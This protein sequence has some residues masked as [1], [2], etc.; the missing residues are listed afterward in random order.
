MTLL[1]WVV[2][3]SLLS[4]ACYAA[5][6][7]VQEQL[8]TA[9]HRNL[10]RWIGALLLTGAGVGLHVIALRLGTVGVVQALGTLT[11]LLALPIA[12]W[13]SRTPITAVA[14]RDAALTVG[15]LA[16]IM[17][18]TADPAGAA[19][20][21]RDA[22]RYVALTALAVVAVLARL[23]R[24]TRTPVARSLAYATAS[25]V[26]FAVAS[27]FTKAVLISFSV[28]GAVCV[29][30]FASGGYLLGQLSYRE[31]GLAAPLAAVSVS[32]PVVAAVVGVVVFG[33]GFRFGASGLTLAVVAG[34]VAGIGVVG[35]SRRTAPDQQPAGDLVSDRSLALQQPRKR[36]SDAWSSVRDIVC[37]ILV[38]AGYQARPVAS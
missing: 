27:V 19:T 32:N 35:L 23:A 17:A 26:A 6:A 14:W 13:R 30:V 31:A 22:G 2:G 28:P 29:A 10:N 37:R 38:K 3:L 9:G 20:L 18:L 11:L 15:G 1:S 21:D 25:G 7:V 8:A 24:H 34:T 36:R 4:A 5:A 12:A 16:G 33:E